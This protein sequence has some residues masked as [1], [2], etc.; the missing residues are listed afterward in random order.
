[1][2]WADQNNNE[3]PNSI[4]QDEQI[5]ADKSELTYNKFLISQYYTATAPLRKHTRHNRITFTTWKV[6]VDCICLG[7]VL[8]GLSS[9]HS[10]LKLSLELASLTSL[11][12]S[13]AG[14]G[15]VPSH[16]CVLGTH[17]NEFT[18]PIAALNKCYRNHTVS[19]NALQLWTYGDSIIGE[20]TGRITPR[21]LKARRLASRAR[22]IFSLFLIL[23][24][25]AKC[26]W[27]WSKDCEIS[28]ND[29][30][31]TQARY[32][33]RR[34]QFCKRLTL[35]APWLPYAPPALNNKNNFWI[36]EFSSTVC[37]WTGRILY[38]RPSGGIWFL[39]AFAK[40]RKATINFMSICP[41]G[42][43]VPTRRI[44]MKLH[45]WAFFFF[46]KS[47]EKIQVSLKSDKNNVTLHEDVFTFMTISR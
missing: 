31:Q 30:Q 37:L 28:W 9:S 18:R 10:V 34:I 1:M 36:Y 7:T 35:P 23:V 33:I 2:I 40:L 15:T 3:N 27:P 17:L 38:R 11:L 20:W 8:I 6:R 45:I 25:T 13:C 39:G 41:H 42:N 46:R 29:I 5:L 4:F 26:F 12:P 43:L 32:T 16:P 14:V 24:D 21:I 22:I 19:S 44:S 47:V